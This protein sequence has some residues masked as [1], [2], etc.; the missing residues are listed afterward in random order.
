MKPIMLVM[1]PMLVAFTL[2][3]QQT[4]PSPAHS[5]PQALSKVERVGE[6]NLRSFFMFSV[7]G[8]DYTIRADGRGERSFEN[9]RSRN[10]NL[11]VAQSHIEQLFFL[12]HE[13][14]LLL[15]YTLSDKERVRGFV[16]R[17]NQTSLK[18]IWLK[19]LL[20]VDFE[21]A[22]VEADFLSFRTGTTTVKLDLRT[23][24]AVEN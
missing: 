19:P 20:G 12:E 16:V 1:L 17:L 11:T 3:Q 9:A 4:A 10:F 23:G 24:A 5:E 15:L 14:D 7:A 13:G 2:G 6:D 21:T 18:A 8:H 22:R